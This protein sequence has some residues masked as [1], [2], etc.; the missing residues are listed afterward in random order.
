M[1]VLNLLILGLIATASPAFADCSDQ[2]MVLK[3]ETGKLGFRVELVPGESGAGGQALI[4]R[5]FV[6][7]PDKYELTVDPLSA[8][9]SRY[10]LIGP[11]GRLKLDVGSN[12]VATVESN[13]DFPSRWRLACN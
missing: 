7:R 3:P 12:G 1:R 4:Y 9:G 5:P 13:R 2:R 6:A 10:I 11:A 8:D